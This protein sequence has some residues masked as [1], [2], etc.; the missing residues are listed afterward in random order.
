M[1]RRYLAF[2]I[3]TAAVISGTGFNWRQHR[4]LGVCCAAA[5]HADLEKAIVW[6]GKQPDGSFAPR[7]SKAEI[8]SMVHDL[9]EFVTNQGFT[10][11]TWNGAGFDLDVLCEESGATDECR[12]LA[13]DHVDMMFH[14]H[15]HQGYPVALDK[16][17]QA[18]NVARKTAGMSGGMAPQH[19]ANGRYQDVIDYVS[20]DVLVALQIVTRCEE[21]QMFH[22][23]TSRGK[24]SSL[25]LSRGWLTVR[26]ALALPEPD[27]SWMDR[28]IP[29]SNYVSWLYG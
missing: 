23:I 8:H 24:H 29:R 25:H 10:L 20:Q 1:T 17:A 27:T 9:V 19:W 14:I 12:Q 22:W 5:I 4:P 13:W 26:E 28:P 18:L 7:M 15:C 3:E 16:A 6:H 2:D 11:L 21:L